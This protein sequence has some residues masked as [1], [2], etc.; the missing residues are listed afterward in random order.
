MNDTSKNILE[1]IKKEG[2]K[3][4]PRW[5]YILAHVLL[6]AA[7]VMATL[8]GGLIMAVVFLKL[9]NL[10]WEFVSILGEHGLPKIFDVLP[11]LWIA[12]LLLVLLLAVMI[13]E[14][15]EEGYKYSPV[16]V[17]V[18]AVVI[19]MLLGGIIYAA[20]WAS[21]FEEAMR[22]GLPFYEQME[23]EREGRFNLPEMGILPGRVVTVTSRSLMEM[24]DLHDHD[25]Q[26]QVQPMA[27]NRVDLT[28]L[29]PGQLVFAIGEKQTD[30]LFMAK[31]VRAK[32]GVTI[33]VMT[34]TMGRAGAVNPPPPGNLLAL[35]VAGS[36]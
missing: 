34:R 10:D 25:W 13:F 33:R 30:D 17:V 4:R 31:D 16:W 19:S 29:R 18:G 28:G 35:P 2:I 22:S 21:R 27:I 15:T 36:P 5:R 7:L 3:P 26:I 6:L 23:S 11:L 8:V 9:G 1:Q 12:C 32:R 24:E 20:D 14:R